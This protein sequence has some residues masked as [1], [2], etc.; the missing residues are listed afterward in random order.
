MRNTLMTC[1]VCFS[2]LCGAAAA[3]AGEVVYLLQQQ[4]CAKI[5]SAAVKLG[6]S[7]YWDRR[8]GFALDRNAAL[9]I[10]K[11]ECG[12]TAGALT[13]A[14]ISQCKESCENMSKKE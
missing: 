14:E 11:T 9:N 5:A 12:F 6:C 10:C 7:L 2:L 13:S 1:C 8:I 3:R 4:Y